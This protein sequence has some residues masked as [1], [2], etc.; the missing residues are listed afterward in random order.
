AMP[1]ASRESEMR[2][3]AVAFLDALGFKTISKKYRAERLVEDLRWLTDGGVWADPPFETDNVRLESRI[4][5]V[6]D[7]IVVTAEVA[8]GPGSREARNDTFCK[9]V[10]LTSVCSKAGMVCAALGKSDTPLV[11]RGAVGLGE[12]LH[13]DG[14]LIGSAID[15][16]AE[17]ERDA[18]A[19]IVWFCPS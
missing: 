8:S 5:M 18:D 14:L 2:Y 11:Y 7:T 19:G 16:T 9:M 17:H 13:D 6:S 12:F 4:V 1:D 15:E 10:A 3:G